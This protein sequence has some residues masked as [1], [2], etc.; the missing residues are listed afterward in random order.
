[1]KSTKENIDPRVDDVRN[2]YVL[3]LGY[4]MVILL[5]YA[6]GVALMATLA[7]AEKLDCSLYDIGQG[8]LKFDKIGALNIESCVVTRKQYVE[9]KMASLLNVTTEK[10]SDS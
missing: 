10:Q 2:Y 4:N 6:D 9:A 8:S 1:M 5:P 7:K 3:N